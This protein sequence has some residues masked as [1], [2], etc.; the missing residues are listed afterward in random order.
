MEES[1]SCIPGVAA[2][3]YGPDA[4]ALGLGLNTSRGMQRYGRS[5]AQL[6][7]GS[8]FASRLEA[9]PAYEHVLAADRVNTEVFSPP[10][11]R[12]IRPDR[13]N[14]CCVCL[15]VQVLAVGGGLGIRDGVFTHK[16]TSTKGRAPS[17]AATWVLLRVNRCVLEMCGLLTQSRYPRLHVFTQC[18]TSSHLSLLL[19]RSHQR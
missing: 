19:S 17:A 2:A 13:G 16:S 11:W 1:S 10:A 5:R 18:V 4:A 14:Q 15:R 8:S 3:L 6:P 7:A 9:R 12:S